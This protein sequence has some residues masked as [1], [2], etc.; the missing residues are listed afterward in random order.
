MILI[1]LDNNQSLCIEKY[2]TRVR[3]V[4]VQNANEK[5]C[6]KEHLNTIEHFLT[7]TDCTLFKGRLQ[8]RKQSDYLFVLL[9]GESIGQ[10][11][12]E[13]LSQKL[14]ELSSKH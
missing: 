13:Y 9:K 4:I 12:T 10:I 5:A 8:L 2:D 3:L 1:A 11:S 7:N 14:L 6:R